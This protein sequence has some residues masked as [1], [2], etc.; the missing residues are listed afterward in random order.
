LNTFQC[1]LL[2]VCEYSLREGILL[3]A[4]AAL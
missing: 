1:D 2:T 3:K 4:F